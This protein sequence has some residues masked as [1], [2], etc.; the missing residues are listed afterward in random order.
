MQVPAGLYLLHTSN[1][2]TTEKMSLSDWL[3]RKHLPFGLQFCRVA[4]GGSGGIFKSNPYLVFIDSFEHIRDPGCPQY[5]A[6]KIITDLI[7]ED[8]EDFTKLKKHFFN[9]HLMK[10]KH[11]M[12]LDMPK[13]TPG[14]DK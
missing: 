6:D 7:L 2:S 4:V 13:D 10:K 3:S 12:K 11:P 5:V 14:S 9:V 8:D 1:F